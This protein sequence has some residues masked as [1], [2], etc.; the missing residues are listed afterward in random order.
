[1]LPNKQYYIRAGSDFV[2][3]PHDVLAGMFGR[4]PQPHVYHHF[5]LS[6]AELKRD[7]LNVSLGI[8]VHNEGPGIASDIFVICLLRELPGPNCTMRFA[9]HDKTNWTGGMELGRQI[10]LISAPGYRLPPGAMAQPLAVHLSLA[11]PFEHDLKISGSA[12]S[13]QSQKYEFSIGSTASNIEQEYND[14]IGFSRKNS[15][16]ENQKHEI[17][18]SILGVS[19]ASTGT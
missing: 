12:G 1:M 17:A 7:T 4:R 8:A 3:T 13:G 14:F 9:P 18:S 11:P 10:N 15:F 5:L 6:E 16:K 19:N 2:P